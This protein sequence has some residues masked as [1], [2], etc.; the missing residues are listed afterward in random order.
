[1]RRAWA[2]GLA[3]WWLGCGGSPGP[4]D[5]GSDDPGVDVADSATDVGPVCRTVADCT[6]TDPGPCGRVECTDAGA[7]EV[8]PDEAREG[9]T[10]DPADRCAVG[11]GACRAGACVPVARKT[12][13]E[14]TCLVG[15]CDGSS[16]EC[17]YESVPD[18]QGCEADENPCTADQCVGGACQAG[19]NDCA[20]TGDGDCPK[21]VGKCDPVLRCIPDSGLCVPD[22]DTP[23]CPA[24]ADPCRTSSC[25]EVSGECV[26]RFLPDLTEC[27]SGSK[28]F[29]AG[30][31]RAGACQQ[32]PRCADED[33][34]TEDRCDA[35]TGTCSHPPADGASC[36]DGD[37]CT[38]DDKCLAGAC[39]P[40]AARVCDDGNPC[41]ID[42]CVT[43]HGCVGTPDVAKGCDDEDAC[44]TDDACGPEGTCE[45]RPIDCDDGNPCTADACDPGTGTCRRDL[46]DGTSCDDGHACTAGDT[47]LAGA[48]EPGPWTTAC[49]EGETDCDD[50]DACTIEHCSDGTCSWDGEPAGWC[51]AQVDAC[52]AAWCTAQAAECQALDLRLPRRLLAWDLRSGG[53]APGFRWS[54]GS[55]MRAAAG[56]G[57]TPGAGWASFS[58]PGRRVP[59]GLAILVLDLGTSGCNAVTLRRDGLEVPASECRPVDGRTRAAW[60]WPGT[61]SPLD[62]MVRVEAGAVVAGADLYL[63]ALDGCAPLGP[64]LVA[65]GEGF[66]DIASVGDTPSAGIRVVGKQTL[67]VVSGGFRFDSGILGWTKLSTESLETQEGRFGIAVNPRPG[68]EGFVVSYG[69]TRRQVVSST[70]TTGGDLLKQ[71]VLS[72]TVLSIDE[73]RF[74]PST[75]VAPSGALWMA[76]SLSPVGS[77]TLDLGFTTGTVLADTPTFDATG[78]LLNQDTEG[79]QRRPRLAVVGEG[80]VAGWISEQAGPL[81]RVILRRLA[82]DGT[83]VGDEVAVDEGVDGLRDLVLAPMGPGH[84]AWV[85]ERDGGVLRAGIRSSLDLAQAESVVFPAGELVRRYSPDL[86]SFGDMTLMASVGVGASARVVLTTLG[87]DASL[88][89]D[90]PLS[91]PIE[92][93]SAAPA[94]AS[95]EP[96]WAAVA[97]FDGSDDRP[98]GIYLTLTAPACVHGPVDCREPA[99][100]QVCVGFGPTGYAP[101]PGASAWCP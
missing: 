43:G 39:A 36:E 46:L 96:Y 71:S 12:C 34:C 21:P 25:D 63:W 24:P 28:C 48:C 17:G 59:A 77:S 14:R 67:D 88:G 42:A 76:W 56:A 18:G 31:C 16:G 49:C 100:P 26:E 66:S 45:G 38:L 91:P 95:L 58:V 55:G 20:C 78:T 3:V 53:A 79:I 57:P 40:G 7:C 54:G 50:G 41:T 8:R 72:T 37:S 64:V 65:A 19:G 92:K 81:N 83:P 69:G 35:A 90:V 13:S 10:C 44:T 89:P 11:K 84:I 101:V 23:R 82:A 99:T 47:C 29:E 68:A 86:V 85:A 33:P 27:E 9:A 73:F 61:G 98:S 75:V 87:G 70:V 97:W 51:G 52:G 80:G 1:M 62:V 2:I 5:T 4:Q 15:Q 60:S 32:A 22:T 94:V 30:T 6:A 93:S 74:E